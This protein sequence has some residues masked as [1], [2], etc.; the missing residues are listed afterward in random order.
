MT[1]ECTHDSTWSLAKTSY[2]RFREGP[3]IFREA[4]LVTSHFLENN[5]TSIGAQLYGQWNNMASMN[6]QMHGKWIVL[7]HQQDF[8][9][10]SET[11]WDWWKFSTHQK[12]FPPSSHTRFLPPRGRLEENNPT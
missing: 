1:L 4:P 5:M 11:L 8:M 12:K 10:V 3:L 2:S 9:E 6:A 7:E